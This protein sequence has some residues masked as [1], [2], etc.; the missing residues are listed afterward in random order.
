MW[1]VPDQICYFLTFG[2]FDFAV[3]YSSN[4]LQT[5]CF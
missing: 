5:T 2:V 1:P 4:A 3:L